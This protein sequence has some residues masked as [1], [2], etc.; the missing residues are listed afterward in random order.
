MKILS[1]FLSA[2]LD[3]IAPFTVRCAAFP[4]T[5]HHC[6]TW[7]SALE[8]VRCYEAA[9]FGAVTVYD[10]HGEVAAVKTAPR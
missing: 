7:A 5:S 10:F 8:W 9:E 6:W 4:K 3:C 1:A 2:S